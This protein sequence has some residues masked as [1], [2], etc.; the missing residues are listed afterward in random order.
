[1]SDEIF[2]VARNGAYISL[3]IET[4][5]SFNDR[6]HG[7]HFVSTDD[8]IEWLMLFRDAPFILVY[9]SSLQEGSINYIFTRRV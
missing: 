8:P 6:N 9:A 1:M 2:R 5:N 4:E 7:D 3:P